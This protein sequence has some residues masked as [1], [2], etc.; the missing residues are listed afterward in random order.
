MLND[1]EREKR[2]EKRLMDIEW[3]VINVEHS[4]IPLGLNERVYAHA[5]ASSNHQSTINNHQFFPR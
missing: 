1:E 2:G 4:E 5:G 3:R